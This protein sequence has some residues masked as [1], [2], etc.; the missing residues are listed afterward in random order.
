MPTNLASL[1]AKY[2]F[3]QLQLADLVGVTKLT[4][5][6][7]ERGE[8]VPRKYYRD[9]LCEALECNEEDL[10]FARDLVSLAVTNAPQDLVVPLYDIAIPFVPKH[11]LVGREHDLIRI[12]AV[13]QETESSIVQAALNGLPGVGK[14]SLAITLVHDPAIRAYFSDGVLWVSLGPIPILAGLL[15]RCAGLFGISETQ[16]AELGEYQKR[17][18]LRTA[19]GISSM[20]RV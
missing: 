6:R 11:P 3:S 7:W 20:L 15:S 12:K 18:I 10:G 16:F 2:N 1:R 13:L 8:A 19:I 5:G 17:Q 4:L 14:T 9:K